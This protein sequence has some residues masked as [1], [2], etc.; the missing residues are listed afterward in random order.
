M[1]EITK[2]A[3]RYPGRQHRLVRPVLPGTPCVGSGAAALLG[4]ADRHLPLPRSALRELVDPPRGAARRPARPRRRDPVRHP[5]RARK[6]RLPADRA[7]DHDGPDVQKR[8]PDERIRRACREG[9][10]EGHRCGDRSRANSASAD[11]D[12]QLRLHLRRVSA[13]DFHRARRQRPNR[14]RHGRDRRDAHRHDPRDL[15]HSALL[16]PRSPGRARRNR[17]SSASASA[18]GPRHRHEARRR[19]A[20]PARHQLHD[21]G[22]E[23]RPRRSGDPSLVA[24]RQ[25]LFG[26]SRSRPPGGNLSADLHRS[27]AADADRAGVRQQSRPD[28][29]CGKHR[30]GA[31]AV[32][33]SSARSSFRNSMRPPAPQ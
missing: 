8:D 2:L 14:D 19:P 7:A 21:D 20:R 24:G 15:L 13:G 5:A 17:R 28:G 22:A 10:Q 25:S 11:P 23:A 16:R 26:A 12:D 3:A 33:S 4:F 6:R 1:N 27:A 29:R 18:G 9:R 31:R 30:C 32:S